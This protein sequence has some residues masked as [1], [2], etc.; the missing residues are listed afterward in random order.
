M[1][2]LSSWSSSACSISTLCTCNSSLCTLDYC[3]RLF[4]R[5]E[6]LSWGYCLG[7]IDL[8]YYWGANCPGTVYHILHN[9]QNTELKLVL[10]MTLLCCVLSYLFDLCCTVS[11]L[12]TC[13]VSGAAFCCEGWTFGPS[14]PF[15]YCT[16]KG[17]FGCGLIGMEWSPR[18]AAFLADDPSFQILHLPEVLLFL[19]RDRERIWV[20][21]LNKSIEW[22]TEWMKISLIIGQYWPNWATDAKKYYPCRWIWCGDVFSFSS[23]DYGQ[24]DDWPSNRWQTFPEYI[25]QCTTT[26]TKNRAYMYMYVGLFAAVSAL[27]ILKQYRVQIGA[28]HRGS[29][30]EL[31]HCLTLEFMI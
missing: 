13:R 23:N 15:R 12:E 29:A 2:W 3:P 20:E 7:V 4:V 28:D 1:S 10:L 11:V 16:A 9:L 18:W 25:Q 24:L 19:W 31:R 17:L 21:A 26:V 8:G 5:R 30:I 6:W 27:Q 22:L 14:G